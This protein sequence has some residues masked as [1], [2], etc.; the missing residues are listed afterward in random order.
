MLQQ[1]TQHGFQRRE[2]TLKPR[3]KLCQP[4]HGI[5]LHFCFIQ[6]VSDLAVL[7]WRYA[8]IIFNYSGV[9]FDRSEAYG[10]GHCKTI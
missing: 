9:C 1:E 7:M 10:R 8:R 3:P 2:Q 5:L 6:I 4:S